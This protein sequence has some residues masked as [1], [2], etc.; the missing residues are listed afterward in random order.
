MST[1]P[2]LPPIDQSLVPESVR[3]AGPKVVSLYDTALSFESVLDQQL[4]QALTDTLQPADSSD[5]GS[6]D[7]SSPDASTSM[8]LQM[9]PQALSQNLAASGGLGI[10]PELYQSL[11]QSEG[12][13]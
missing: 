10:A 11:A 2:G 9:L 8:M 3:T 4:T 13:Q 6:G 1:S 5:D 12:T 7:G